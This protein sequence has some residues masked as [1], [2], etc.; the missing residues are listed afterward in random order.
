MAT[1]PT[2]F[3]LPGDPVRLAHDSTMRAAWTR[4][5][6]NA[7]RTLDSFEMAGKPYGI[8]LEIIDRRSRHEVLLADLCAYVV[9]EL[10]NAAGGGAG[11]RD[12]ARRLRQIRGIIR[13]EPGEAGIRL[14][15][16]EEPNPVLQPAGTLLVDLR[17]PLSP[18]GSIPVGSW[19]AAI[20]SQLHESGLARA[21]AEYALALD[22]PSAAGFA[23]PDRILGDAFRALGQ[24]ATYLP[25]TPEQR[26]T[27]SELWLTP[28]AGREDSEPGYRLRIWR[29]GIM[30]IA[31]SARRV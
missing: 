29:F 21:G 16:L 2:D 30:Q 5:L 14:H 28:A 8:T 1:D 26:S 25:S 10:L 23:E 15:L 27:G 12:T 11:D 3:W 17:P 24:I 18:A 9:D 22:L 6:N 31:P 4:V 19:E 20:R 7:A 13:P